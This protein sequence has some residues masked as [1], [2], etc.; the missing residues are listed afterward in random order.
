[1]T[2]TVAPP[3]PEAPAPDEA[4]IP[5]TTETI[6]GPTE[7]AGF[8]WDAPDP[9]PEPGPSTSAPSA[10]GSLDA[11][12]YGAIAGL[13][14]SL[15]ELTGWEGWRFTPADED[16]WRAL[17]RPLLVGIDP[18]KWGIAFAILGVAML[19]TGRLVGYLR[20]RRSRAPPP[21]RATAPQPRPAPDPEVGEVP[22]VPLGKP[23]QHEGD[24]L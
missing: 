9:R 13:H 10:P 6:E 16:S 8:S 15:A 22:D 12:A 18:K 17:L 19:E 3:A 7:Q 4:P 1:M 21:A 23:L 5:P 14:S 20:Y 24:G 11:L 2:V